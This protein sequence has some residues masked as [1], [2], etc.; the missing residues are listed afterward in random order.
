VA[1]GLYDL[2]SGQRLP[3]LD[4]GAARLKDDALVIPIGG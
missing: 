3:A 1:I 2:T 4:A